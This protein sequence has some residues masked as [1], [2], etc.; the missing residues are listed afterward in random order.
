MNLSFRCVLVGG[1][2]LLIQCAELLAQRGHTVAAVVTQRAAI[3]Q[4]ALKQGIRVLRD[5]QALLQATDVQPF[6][7]LLSITNLSVLSPAVLALPKLGAINFHDGPL[8]AY[9]GLNTPVWALLDGAS[10]YG[11]TWHRMTADVDRG[12][13]LVQRLFDINSSSLDSEA[14][15]E[16]ALTLNTKNY[17]AAVDGFEALIDGLQAGTLQ[18][19]PQDR[20]IERYFGRKDRPAAMACI[21]WRASAASIVRLVRALDFGGYANPVASAKASVGEHALRITRAVTMPAVPGAAPGTVVGGDAQSIRV[22]AADGVV[23]LLALETLDGRVLTPLQALDTWGLTQRVQAGVQLDVFND[24]TRQRLGELN[25][26]V[27]AFEG[28]WLQRLQER[29]D[30][31]LPY[32]DRKSTLAPQP[33]ALNATMA[34]PFGDAKLTPNRVAHVTAMALL[35]LARLADKDSFDVGYAGPALQALQPG[36]LGLLAKHVPLNVTLDFATPFSAWQASTAAQLEQLDKR[37]SYALDVV[38]RTPTLRAAAAQGQPLQQAVVLT[39]V[40]DV[41]GASMAPGSELTIAFALGASDASV[42]TRWCFDA[43]KL[44]PVHVQAMQAQLQSLLNAAANDSQRGMGT[45]PLMDADQ[46]QRLTVGWNHNVAP[47]R[48]DVGVH[49]LIEQQA[50]RTPHHVA[51]TAQGRSLSYAE[52]DAKANQLA[53]KLATLG[54]KPDVLVGLMCERSVEMMVGLLAIHKAGGAYVPL[55][56]SYPRDRIAAMIEDAKAPVVLTLAH[57]RDDMSV[58]LAATKAQAIALDAD[59]PSIASLPNTPFDGGAQPEHMAYVIYTSGST[60]KPKGVMVEHRNVVNF[61]AGMDQHLGGDA[62]G[63]WLAVTSLSFDISV[64]ELCWTLTRGFHVVISSD[65]DRSTAGPARGAHAARPLDFSLFY[66]SS[67]ES[68]GV[69]DKYKLLLEGAKYG[70]Q[71][72]FK[73]VWTPERHFHAFGGLYPNPAVTGAAI[74]AIT[75]RVQIRSGSVVLPLHHPLRVAEEW[76]VVDNISKGR[77][78]VSFAS[79]WQPDDFVLMPQNFADNKGVLTRN[80][81]LV[82]SLWRGNAHS[83][84]GPLGKPVEVRVL[85]RP[86]QAELPFWITAAGNPETFAT[87]GRMGANVLTHL[88]GQTIEELKDKL[89]AYRQARRDAGHPGEGI[90]S[91]MLHTFVGPDEEA[92]R[93]KVKQPMIEYLRSSVNLVKQYAWAFPAFK[94]REGMDTGAQAV[95]LST[96]S[97]EEMDALLAFSF[98]RYYETSGLFGTPESC[99]KT[100]DAIKAIG[101][102]DVACLIDFGVDSA[103]VLEHLPYLNELRKLSRPPRVADTQF[104][105]PALLQQHAITHLQCT[106]S[107][108]R[109]LLLD[110]ASKAGLRKLQRMMVG[111]EALQPALAQELTSVVPGQLMNMYGPTET[112]IWSSVHTVGAVE[113]PIPLGRALVNQAVYILDRRQQPLPVGVPGE[114]IIG[115]QGV[116]RGYLHRPELTA[117]KFLTHPLKAA[118]GQ[119]LPGRVY[120]TGD[121]ARWRDDGMVVFLGR[122]DHQVKVRGYRIELGEIEAALAQQAN[123]SETVV[124]AREDTPGDVRL[125]AYLVAKPGA[126]LTVAALKSALRDSLPDFMVPAHFVVLDA[127]PQTPNGKIDRKQLP[128]PDHALQAAVAVEYVAP[129]GDLEAT[130]VDVWKDVLKVPKVGMRDNFFDLGGHSLLAIQVL[131][132]LKER[133]QRDIGI[134]DIFRFPTVQTLAAHLSDG[135]AQGAAVKQGQD[136]AEGRRAAMAARRGGARDSAAP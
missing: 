30:Y 56:P 136:R 107:M 120:R 53:R 133:L 35:L 3:R 88:L 134:T 52:L 46:L 41:N 77:V 78:G 122:L 89:Q 31:E 15:A 132:V 5:G 126:E 51:I 108:A 115:G 33:Q 128:A 110:E 21:D 73:A 59:W 38:G 114:L 104:S 60:G 7:Y 74:A 2:S 8:P 100:I 72:G 92:V 24:V 123:V 23:A 103:S 48:R 98:D 50:A 13:V 28:H 80:I 102:D 70:D 81:E 106:P 58:E 29:S 91:L 66:F 47:V 68:E 112:T 124:V 54:V 96:V 121:L 97:K 63:T 76:S 86:V 111:G 12:D 57:W 116:V 87:A 17:G 26:Q 75:S 45:L 9:A 93:A 39:W 113:G 32:V 101:V 11:I 82:R 37:G 85:P 18:G 83:F 79:G 1:E 65:E 14:S 64:L 19:T 84:D 61:F 16:T 44:K 127:L 105:L 20:P 6:D 117:E 129:S 125:V 99:L 130:I 94:R 25:A 119:A 27:A 118:D 135:A 131:R 40:D 55:D 67:D 4:W 34:L 90:V 69:S 95:D 22:A 10:T 109:M 42:Q 62:P 49:H 71:H 36:S 43:S